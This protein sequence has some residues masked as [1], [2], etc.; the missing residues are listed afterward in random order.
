M[1]E[2]LSIAI[3]FLSAGLLLFV[4]G[5]MRIVS[6]KFCV[7]LFLSSFI[8][9]GFYC[10]KVFHE[11]IVPL[12]GFSAETNNLLFNDYGLGLLGLLPLTLSILFIGKYIL[13]MNY[14][15]QWGG[16]V[17]FK[18]PSLTYG[19]IAGLLISVVPLAI[20]ALKGYKFDYKIDFYLYG[21]N[22][23]TNLYE[24]VIFRGLLLACCVK[25][26]SRIAAVVW[27]SAVFGLGHGLNEKSILIAL[28]ACL[29]AWAVLKAKSLWAGWT[30]H[31]LADMIVDT[32]LH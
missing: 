25:Y 19:I 1:N 6:D 22:C 4:L 14:K 15:E 10:I 21:T 11:S 7:P 31:Q 5:K 12:L 18:L 3:I 17:K 28:G 29:M 27:T 16:T 8:F 30:T 13:K 32:L 24:E 23:V 9:V 2:S 26:W 20:A